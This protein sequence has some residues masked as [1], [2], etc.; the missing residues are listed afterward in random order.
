MEVYIGDRKT[1]SCFSAYNKVRY[2]CADF[3][4]YRP[5]L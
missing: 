2:L 3:D 5:G 1:G 4:M